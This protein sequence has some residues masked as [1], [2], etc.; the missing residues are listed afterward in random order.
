MEEE[1]SAEAIEGQQDV[2]KGNQPL[3]LWKIPTHA[4]M[5]RTYSAAGIAERSVS[6]PIVAM[7]TASGTV[8]VDWYTTGKS[9]IQHRVGMK[10]ATLWS[11]VGFLWS[12]PLLSSLTLR[13]DDPANPQNWNDGKKV[14]GVISDL[15]SRKYP[16]Q[17]LQILNSYSI[18]SFT[19]LAF[20]PPPLPF[21]PFLFVRGFLRSCG[22]KGK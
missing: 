22:I 2:E 15:A 18:Y 1:T 20:L 21:S 10:H 3:G 6:R 14:F 16:F 13:L 4:E 9:N 19:V 17:L 12:L 8:L 7:K 5:Q 11:C